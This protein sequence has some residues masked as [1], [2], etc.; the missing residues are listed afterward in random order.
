M[1]TKSKNRLFTNMF[2]YA[3]LQIVNM[4]VGLFLPRLYLEVYGS[5]IN[6][7][8][9]T[10]N[11]F[12][13]YFHYLE[14]G[15]GLTLIHSLFKPLADNNTK[16]LNGI[17]SYSKKQYQKISFLYFILVVAFSLVFPRLKSIHDIGQTEFTLLILVIGIYGSLDFYTMSKYRVLLTADRKEYIISYAMILAQF[18]RFI[19]V[20]ILLKFN[21][22]VVVVKI[23][24]I[25]TLFARSVIL[26]VY[27]KRK[28]KNIDYNSK[29]R[30]SVKTTKE[31]WDALILQ[32]SISTAI[33]LPTILVSQFLGYKEA[34]VYAVYS[35]V[36]SSMIS[37][38]SSL[39][40]GLAPML[41][42]SISQGK[43]IIK[44]YEILDFVV[45]FIIAVIFS[46][47][48]VMML[49]FVELYT[50]VV[51]D[52][53]YIH[54]E[55]AIFM[56]IWGAIY[57][58]RIP[59]TA[60]VNAAGIYRENRV[61][62]IVNLLIQVTL[63]VVSVWFF[64]VS[65]LIIVMIIAA[66]QRNISLSVVNSRAI[67]HSDIKDSILYHIVLII[68]IVGSYFMWGSILPT[69]EYDVFRWVIVSVIVASVEV[70]ICS[71]VFFMV[72]R[73]VAIMVLDMIKSKLLPSEKRG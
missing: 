37:I 58:Y 2:S 62:N 47:T 9:S 25:F 72:N 5:E 60:V 4:L 53:N 40:S 49:P 46:T 27:I 21:L 59:V 6:G 36:I 20:W 41:G 64:K 14:A 23:V 68:L 44:E 38:T 35:L 69:M 56:S 65:G 17:L 61:N 39:S 48:A 3:L 43:N 52:I 7:A 42:R 33:S 66:V 71:C 16:E 32:I 54:P 29:E 70:L 31:H 28:Y 45:A 12:T 30:I 63:G 34:N 10:I 1:R 57:V 67:L 18:L 26:R 51:D 15:L 24:P 19:F 11:S 73:K 13:S 22:S 50:N 55:F 8:V